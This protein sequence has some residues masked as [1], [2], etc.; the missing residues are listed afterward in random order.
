MLKCVTAGYVPYLSPLAPRNLE[1]L[2]PIVIYPLIY[3]T[4]RKDTPL[5][6][7]K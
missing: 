3:T 4:L 1:T 5:F 2:K 6:C 7:P